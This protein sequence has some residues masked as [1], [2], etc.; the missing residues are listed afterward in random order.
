MKRLLLV[1][2]VSL[3][4]TTA[5][6][7]CAPMGSHAAAPKAT[8]AAAQVMSLK[9]AGETYERLAAKSNGAREAWLHG[10]K[11]TEANLAE[12][13]TLAGQ[14]AKV[15]SDFAT[16]IR[17]HSWPAQSRRPLDALRKDLEVRAAA[18]RK[19]AA[20]R[21]IE[22]YVAA[23]RHVPLSSP[24]AA[25]VRRSLKLSEAPA[26]CVCDTPSGPTAG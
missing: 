10:P 13:R 14:A 8:S 11:L 16:T 3:A 19:V 1:A 4:V 20:A 7:G 5:L 15:T 25:E 6:T 17:T 24:A 26:F 2:T 18:Y 23:A 9:Q 12:H 21:T 22:Q